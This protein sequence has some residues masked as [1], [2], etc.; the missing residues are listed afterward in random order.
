L[1]L[2]CQFDSEYFVE[3]DL[4]DGNTFAIGHHPTAPFVP[5]GGIMFAVDNAEEAGQRAESLGGKVV[6][7]MGGEI[8]TTAW[9]TDP[10]GNWFGLHQRL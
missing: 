6:A 1:G 3:Y 10:D 5:M 8:C 9:C 7:K 2:D 4:S